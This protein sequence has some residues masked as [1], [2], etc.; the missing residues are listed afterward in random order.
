MKTMSLMAAAAVCLAH[1]AGS[2]TA[3]ADDFTVTKDVTDGL[4]T[5]TDSNSAVGVVELVVAG[6][7]TTAG[8]TLPGWSATA[9]LFDDPL[10]CQPA[11][12]STIESGFCYLLTNTG[13]GT[14]IVD[15]TVSFTYDSSFDDPTTPSEYAVVYESANGLVGACF[16]QTGSGCSVAVAEPVMPWT[17]AAATLGVFA[18]YGRRRILSAGR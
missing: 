10:N 3:R 17:F 2:G 8:T 15:Q 9:F 6:L 11:I 18:L 16:G 7:G 1:L 5:L 14:P 12:G 4:F 13:V